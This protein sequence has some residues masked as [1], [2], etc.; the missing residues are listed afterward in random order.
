VILLP[1]G[2]ASS[3]IIQSVSEGIRHA[4][5]KCSIAHYYTDMAKNMHI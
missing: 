2:D 3:L 5:G 1:L 4:L